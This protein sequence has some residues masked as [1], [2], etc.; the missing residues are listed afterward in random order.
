[1][2][3]ESK[4]GGYEAH[5]TFDKSHA[6]AVEGYAETIRGWNWVYSVITGCPILGSGTYCYLTGYNKDNP[7]A[8]KADMDAIAIDLKGMDVPCLRSKI[9]HIVYDSKTHVNEL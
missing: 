6:A 8:L 7:K 5:L 9:E 4:P 2:K 3:T 1:M